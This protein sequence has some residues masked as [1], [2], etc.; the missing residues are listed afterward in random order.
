MKKLLILVVALALLA[1]PAQATPAEDNAQEYAA[2]LEGDWTCIY[3]GGALAP[4][5]LSFDANGVSGYG[6]PY[7]WVVSCGDGT[8]SIYAYMSSMSFWVGKVYLTP[9]GNT[10][11]VD[12]GKGDP[13]AYER[14]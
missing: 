1:M 6:K 13:S 4:D 11:I 14:R 2:R 9:D 12:S 8:A 5:H 10:M 7:Y 3:S